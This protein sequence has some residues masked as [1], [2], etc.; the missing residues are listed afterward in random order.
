[1]ATSNLTAAEISLID[2]ATV[3]IDAITQHHTPTN[4]ARIFEATVSSALLS[5]SGRIFTGVNVSHFTGG[6]CAEHVA[7]GN[8]NAAGVVN[9]P[10]KPAARLDG[11]AGSVEAEVEV[12][13]HCVAVTSRGR[14][15]ISP[16]GKCRQMLFDYHPGIK[17]I[18]VGAGG[19][20]TVV[21][22]REL[23]PWAYEW[24]ERVI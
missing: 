16:C 1:M 18:V 17:V 10:P 14:G 23:L 22:M 24:T 3:V 2:A 5:S 4:R 15:V 7:L 11:D 8:A 13:T 21:G 9:C 12:L 19:V 20:L 6:P